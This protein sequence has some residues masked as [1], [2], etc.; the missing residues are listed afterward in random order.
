[1]TREDAL[2]LKQHPSWLELEKEIDAIIN[3][4]RL[5]LE[6]VDPKSID[7]IVIQESI[8]ALRRM[9]NLPQGVVDRET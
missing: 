1:M 2:A 9:K 6:T 7:I 5:K 3:A 4:Q 8:K